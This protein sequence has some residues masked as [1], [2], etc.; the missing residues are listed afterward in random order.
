VSYLPLLLIVLALVLRVL[1]V[2][3]LQP[4]CWAA[5]MIWNEKRC[6][7]DEQFV[8]FFYGPNGLK[9]LAFMRER[10]EGLDWVYDPIGLPVAAPVVKRV[11][12]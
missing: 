2:R 4:W 9:M 12:P 5:A 6:H 3:W 10:D 8:E 1:Y 7:K 11:A